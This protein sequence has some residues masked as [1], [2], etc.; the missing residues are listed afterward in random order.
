M[1]FHFRQ[2]PPRTYE[3]GNLLVYTEEIPPN[4]MKK[5]IFFWTKKL[6]INYQPLFDY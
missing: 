6:G 3:R 5:P 1:I 4:V 2:S